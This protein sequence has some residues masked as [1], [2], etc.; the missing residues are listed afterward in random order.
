LK[1]VIIK[2]VDMR[3]TAIDYIVGDEYLYYTASEQRLVTKLKK[4]SEAY[5]DEVKILAENDDGSVHV[6]SPIRWF[7]APSPPKKV[8]DE[9]R[10]AASERFKAMRNT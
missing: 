8:S 6:R 4:Q 5:P 10:K 3:E 9:Q 1:G 2:M 7:K